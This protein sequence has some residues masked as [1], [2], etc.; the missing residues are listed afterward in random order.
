VKVIAPAL[1]VAL[2]SLA[3]G[4]TFEFSFW[5]PGPSFTDPRIVAIHEGPCGPVATAR[6]ERMPEHSKKEPLAPERVLELGS[7]GSVINQWRIPVD[8]QVLGLAGQ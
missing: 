1:L 4:D 5:P 3:L 8:A 6:V 7:K 2:P